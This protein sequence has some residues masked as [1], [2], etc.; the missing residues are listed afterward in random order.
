MD[1]QSFILNLQGMHKIVHNT[2]KWVRIKI[3][4]ISMDKFLL[5]NFANRKL[6]PDLY[7]HTS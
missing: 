1:F 6:M 5:C 2:E 7:L 3:L 4:N